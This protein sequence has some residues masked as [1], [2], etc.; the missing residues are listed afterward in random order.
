MGSQHAVFP[1]DRWRSSVPLRARSCLF[2]VCSSVI[3]DGE[4]EE[5]QPMARVQHD[6]IPLGSLLHQSIN[7]SGVS[8]PLTGPYLFL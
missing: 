5:G 1:A 3:V 8:S 7:E 2:S 6:D 4:E